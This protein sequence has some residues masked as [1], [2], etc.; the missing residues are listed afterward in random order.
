MNVLGRGERMFRVEKHACV[1]IGDVLR[2][3]EAMNQPVTEQTSSSWRMTEGI[4]LDRWASVAT[5]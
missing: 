1:R 2:A 3:G 4:G 5:G